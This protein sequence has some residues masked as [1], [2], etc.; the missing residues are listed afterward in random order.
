[1]SRFEKY[2]IEKTTDEEFVESVQRDCKFY[3]NLLRGKTA[4]LRS[5]HSNAALGTK[6]VRKDRMPRGMTEKVFHLLNKFLEENGHLKRDNVVFANSSRTVLEKYFDDADIYAIFPKGKFNYTWFKS[7][8]VNVYYHGKWDPDI[9]Y[10][11]FTKKGPDRVY[12]M[13]EKERLVFEA[14][15]KEM[16]VTNKNIHIPH[17]KGFEIWFDCKEYYYLRLPFYEAIRK[18]G[19]L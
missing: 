3:L 4:F 5:M 2:L 18:E 1:M 19:R 15:L 9:M 10:A 11:Y 17:E 8:D 14:K 13:T 12:G 16:F 7:V 6:K